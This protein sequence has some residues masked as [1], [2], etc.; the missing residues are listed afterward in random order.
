MRV[1][2]VVQD[3][4][5]IPLPSVSYQRRAVG[6]RELG[7]D[8]LLER[9]AVTV[10][11][12]I[13]KLIGAQKMLQCPRHACVD[14]VRLK[15]RRMIEPAA[16]MRSRMA[17]IRGVA[18]LYHDPVVA[19]RDAESCLCAVASEL[20]DMGDIE[21]GLPRDADAFDENSSV[22]QTARRDQARK[23]GEIPASTLCKSARVVSPPICAGSSQ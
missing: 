20:V 18:V 12:A 6:L 16:L 11:N 2:H 10:Q 3:D 23:L 4:E 8:S 15:K 5:V 13:R 1:A 7:Y 17:R 14:F 9:R 21:G 19:S 22:E